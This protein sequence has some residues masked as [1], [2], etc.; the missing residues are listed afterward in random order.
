MKYEVVRL[1]EKTVVGL[2]ASTGNA[3]PNMSEI[4]SNLWKNLYQPG[5]YNSINNR[6][7]T[8]AIGLYSDYTK[9]QYHV[10]AGFEVS[11]A[12]NKELTV[13]TI[14]AGNYA[15]FSIHGNMVTAVSEAW[16]EIWNMDL[17][18][19]FTGDFEEYLN[20]D[21]ENADILIYVAIK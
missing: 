2:G 6:I 18:R 10:L 20:D 13:K 16:N 3:D 12:E 17:E 21:W 8:Y 15:K 9:D 4:I 5:L 7:N 11:K 1:E 19:T 14:P